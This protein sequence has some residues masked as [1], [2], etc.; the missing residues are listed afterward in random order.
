MLPNKLTKIQTDQ[1]IDEQYPDH[2][3][4]PDSIL[5]EKSLSAGNRRHELIGLVLYKIRNYEIISV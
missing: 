3:N 1:R 2:K 4:N 5:V